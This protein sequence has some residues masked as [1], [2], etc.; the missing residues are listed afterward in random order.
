MGVGQHVEGERDSFC[1][2]G[3]LIDFSS[4]PSDCQELVD[5]DYAEL[6]GV[7]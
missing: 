3:S 5:R 1:P 6:W 7:E 4:L 2:C